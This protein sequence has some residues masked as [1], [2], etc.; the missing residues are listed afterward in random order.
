MVPEISPA[1]IRQMERLEDE[2][3]LRFA[4]DAVLE[5]MHEHPI[6]AHC[7]LL[8]LPL[9]QSPAN[10]LLLSGTLAGWAWLWQDRRTF[11]QSDIC[12]AWNPYC[13][14]RVL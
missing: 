14:R 7:D 5:F 10:W 4:A 9:S 1:A 6:T 2:R 12:E 8:T 3:M 13:E 11:I